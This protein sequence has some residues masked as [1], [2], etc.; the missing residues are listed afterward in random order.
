MASLRTGILLL[1]VSA[2][3][4]P[5]SAQT[6]S[7]T[8][9]PAQIALACAT[10]SGPMRPAPARILGAQDPLP[11]TLLAPHELLVVASG[12]DAAARLGQPFF[13]RHAPLLAPSGYGRPRGPMSARAGC[14]THSPTGPAS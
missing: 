5:L 11:H 3:L 8:L 12:T 4:S 1:I 9:T 6:L 2:A 10:P 7:D 13:I 14:A